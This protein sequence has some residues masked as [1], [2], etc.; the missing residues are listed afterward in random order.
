MVPVKI[1]IT[2]D[3]T[4]NETEITILCKQIDNELDAVISTLGLINNTVS[5]KRDGETF[6]IPLGAV[7]Y[8]D[9]IENRT[10]FY[11]TDQTYETTTK[12]YQL[13]EKLAST[14]FVRF[15]KSA[16]VNLQKVKSIKSEKNSK[17]VATLTNNE[18]LVVSRQYMQQIKTKLGV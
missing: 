18:K 15:S 3:G 10:F 8:F 17:L 7:L 4:V 2:V 14:S 11:T 6:F 16:L 12:L 5:G 9:T 1:T 13:E